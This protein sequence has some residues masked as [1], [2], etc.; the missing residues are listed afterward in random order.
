MK[1]RFLIKALAAT[2]IFSAILFL[3]AGKINYGGGWIFLATNMISSCMNFWWI[4]NDPE[5]MR[6]RAKIGEGTKSWDKRILILSGITYLF[7]LVVAGLDAGRYH[8]S[9]GFHWSIYFSGILVTLAGQGLFFQARK[10]N[11]YFSSVVRIQSDRGH[12]VCDTGVYKIVRHPGYSGM[13]ISLMGLPLMTGSLWSG[14]PVGL[15]MVLL[16]LR[17]YLEDETLKRELA[18]YSEYAQRTKQRLIPKVW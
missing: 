2:I 1:A 4:R 6:E 18:G 12:A 17:T 10:E 14:I 13:M 5:L 11:R 9:S 15:A 8:W 7:C 3:F 16:F